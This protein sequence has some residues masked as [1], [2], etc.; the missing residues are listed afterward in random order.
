MTNEDI[1]RKFVDVMN[2]LDWDAVYAMMSR[3]IVYHN[4]PFPVLEG[5]GAVRAF[6]AGVGQITDCDWQIKNI[7]SQ[8]DVVLTERLDDF[9]LDGTPVSLPVM[10]AFW[11]RDGKIAEWRDYFDAR[12]FEAQLGRP[13]G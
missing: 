5:V 4:L 6:F 11:I 2:E 8:G 12:T 9:K 13:L 3:D 7:A 1:V 10:G